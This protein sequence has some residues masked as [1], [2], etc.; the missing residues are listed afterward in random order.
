MNRENRLSP[1]CRQAIA[2]PNQ[3]SLS[4]ER[5]GRE[6]T[7]ALIDL[8]W[9]KHAEE[10]EHH[11]PALDGLAVADRMPRRGSSQFPTFSETGSTCGFSAQ[12]T[13][14]EIILRMLSRTGGIANLP[15]GNSDIGFKAL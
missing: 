8:L 9:K 13:A 6:D 7:P 3:V 2:R 4:R 10:F 5:E 14:R 15:C 12:Q 1:D 11:K